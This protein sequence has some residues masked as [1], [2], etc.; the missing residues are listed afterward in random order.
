MVVSI[1]TQVDGCIGVRKPSL[2]RLDQGCRF[3]SGF[4]SIGLM[5]LA[6][7]LRSPNTEEYLIHGII[8]DLINGVYDQQPENNLMNILLIMTLEINKTHLMSNI[9]GCEQMDPE[10]VNLV[11]TSP[12]YDNLREYNDSSTWNFDV[13]KVMMDSFVF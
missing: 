13:F 5:T 2:N 7:G 8:E 11:V 10:S 4:Q 3:A 1:L 9:D 12:P 6:W